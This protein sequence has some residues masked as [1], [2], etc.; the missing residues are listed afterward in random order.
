V[1]LI[2][3]LS[4]GGLLTAFGLSSAT[5]LNAYLPLLVAGILD[6]TG[7]V[8]LGDGFHGL[9]SWPIL[10][11]LAVLLIV[12]LVGDKVPAVDHVFHMVGMVIHPIAGALAF[13]STT[14]AVQHVNPTVALVIGAITGGSLHVARSSVRPVSTLTT[15]GIATPFVS[16][17][18]D[19][20]SG[21]CARGVRVLPA[22]ATAGEVVGQAGP[23]SPTPQRLVP[24][25]LLAE[26]GALFL[27]STAAARSWSEEVEE[28]SHGLCPTLCP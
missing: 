8:K 11:V 4:V 16:A 14:G 2:N 21:G 24:A 17:A 28:L 5:G 15:A 18:E 12:D 20:S 23:A 3:F 26:I 10:A 6:R 27:S 22:A 25:G 19:V 13:A 1:F 9:S 7:A